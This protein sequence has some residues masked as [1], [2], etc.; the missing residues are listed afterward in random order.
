MTARSTGRARKS[1]IGR[2]RSG[3]ARC[4]FRLDRLGCYSTS[5][6]RRQRPRDTPPRCGINDPTTAVHALGHSAALLCEMAEHDLGPVVMTDQDGAVRVVLHRPDLGDLI[7]LAMEQPRRYGAS[8]PA[9]LAQL[10]SML[11]RLAWR[12]PDAGCAAIRG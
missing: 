7:E 6:F 9:V 12:S 5:L 8:D 3:A 1:R 11:R 4:G 2:E 10:Y